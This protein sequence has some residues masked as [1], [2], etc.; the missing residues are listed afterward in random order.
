MTHPNIMKV[1]RTEVNDRV[2][3]NWEIRGVQPL[4]M[5][6]GLQLCLKPECWL[7]R[8]APVTSESGD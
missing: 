4:P 3:G 1:E 8:Q 2:M 5:V 7:C 6:N